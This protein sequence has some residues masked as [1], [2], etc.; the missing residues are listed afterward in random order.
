MM[1]CVS[2]AHAAAETKEEAKVADISL[3]DLKKAIADKKV[4]LLDC[5]GSES[6]K[7]GHIPGAVDFNAVQG[8]LAKSLPEDKGA[9]IVA[10]CGSEKCPAYKAGADAAIK[11]GY[12]NVKHFS[13]GKAGWEKAGEKFETAEAAKM[14]G[15][16][17]AK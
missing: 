17:V 13:G 1:N 3:D 9:L 8:E 11:L 6:Y 12:T 16:P 4:T 2:F 7:A 14:D 5:N 10:Y 15:G